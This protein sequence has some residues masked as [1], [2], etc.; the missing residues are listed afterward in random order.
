[1]RAPRLQGDTGANKSATDALQI[2]HDY[3]QFEVP[4]IVGVFLQNND[5]TEPTTLKA[6][7]KGYY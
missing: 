3:Q 7:G 6:L 5:S 1:M 4:E 2:L